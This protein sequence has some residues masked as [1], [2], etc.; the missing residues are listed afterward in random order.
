VTLSLNVS[1]PEPCMYF[2]SPH[3]CKMPCP[4]HR[5]SFGHPNSIG[6]WG[7]HD[8]KTGRRDIEEE[9]IIYGEEYKSR[10]Y[11]LRNFLHYRLTSA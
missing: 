1:S 10:R 7:G 4:S 6:D 8:L 5:P 9:E 11:S 2:S 3:T